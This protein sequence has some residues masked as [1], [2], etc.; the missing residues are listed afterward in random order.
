MIAE[1]LKKH[2]TIPAVAAA[3]GMTALFGLAILAIGFNALFNPNTQPVLAAPADP[4]AA[5]SADPAALQQMQE[6]IA[7][8]QAREQQYKAELNQA[9]AQLNQANQQLS[10]Y[11][12]LVSGLENAG[13]IQISPDG[14]VFLGGGQRRG[15]GDDGGGD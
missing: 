4:S 11:Q 8:Y 2:K 9:A 3:F 15:G 5:A 10:Q 7:Q 6:L 13:I 1:Y 14:R 12:A